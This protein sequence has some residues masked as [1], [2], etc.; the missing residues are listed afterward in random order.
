MGAGVHILGHSPKVVLDAVKKQMEKGIHYYMPAEIEVKPMAPKYL[1]PVLLDTPDLAEDR[2]RLEL[3]RMGGLVLNMVRRAGPA[4]ARGSKAHLLALARLWSGERENLDEVAQLLDL[5][6]ERQRRPNPDLLGTRAR[7]AVLRG[8]PGA[9]VAL[10]EMS[11]LDGDELADLE[12][13]VERA[14]QEGR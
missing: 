14:R 12:S 10:L 13:L 7:L 4:A 9:A 5:A 1:D 2:I 8:D 3:G 11:E 6:L